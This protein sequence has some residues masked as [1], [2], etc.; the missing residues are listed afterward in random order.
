MST[1]PDKI[2][3]DNECINK[4]SLL[5]EL[6][7]QVNSLRIT[8]PVE[9]Y[10]DNEY[11]KERRRTLLLFGELL[12]DSKDFKK[13]PFSEQLSALISI[14]LSCFN[15]VIAKCKEDAIYVDWSNP[16]FTY[17]YSLICSRV[18]KNLDASAEVDS[19]YLV[20][21][22][23]DKSVE[24]SGLGEMSSEELCPGSVS[25]IINQLN[26]RRSQKLKQ[27]TTNMYTCRNC[28]GRECTIRTQQ[29]RSLDEG[30]T[31]ILNCVNCGFRFMTSG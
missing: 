28:K 11:T 23:S 19:D 31:I 16:N 7:S 6:D 27:K 4:N 15:K 21:G 12:D 22:L 30:F 5:G 24:A 8:L 25:A 1:S 29:M 20:K 17:L 3:S 2:D 26:T 10:L 13:L 18:S 14:E 9:L